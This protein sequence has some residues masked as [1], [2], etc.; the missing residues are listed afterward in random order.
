MGPCHYLVLLYIGVYV[1]EP[2]C[3]VCYSSMVV[4]KLAF[5]AD[6]TYANVSTGFPIRRIESQSV[7]FR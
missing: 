5:T 4:R 7:I 3:Y 1:T 2:V 6:G